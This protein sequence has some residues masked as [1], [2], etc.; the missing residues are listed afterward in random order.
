MNEDI[1]ELKIKEMEIIIA[2]FKR[3][4]VTNDLIDTLVVYDQFNN[5]LCGPVE[6]KEVV[7]TNI[8]NLINDRKF[9]IDCK[10][11]MN[12]AQALKFGDHEDV[13]MIIYSEDPLISLKFYIHRYVSLCNKLI[14]EDNKLILKKKSK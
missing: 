11:A 14:D 9:Y 5:L 12:L 1:S 10:K 7:A 6:D 2:L 8:F 13:L 3:A 4:I